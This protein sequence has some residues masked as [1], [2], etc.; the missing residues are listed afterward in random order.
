MRPS[1]IR[2]L[3]AL[4]F[5]VLFLG[6]LVSAAADYTIEYNWW[7]EIG[8]V[9][10][11]F[12]M[13]WYSI[14]PAAAGTVVAFAAL[15]MTHASGLHFAGIRQRDFPIYSR[16]IPV[17][18]ALVAILFAT[19]SIDYWTAMRFFGSRGIAVPADAWKDQVFSRGLPFYLFDLPFYSQ[20][21]GFVFVLA[22]LCAL[23]FWATARGWQLAERF[24]YGRLTSGPGNQ[25]VLG[26]DTLL[27]PGAT[28]AGI[29]RIISVIL[30]LGFAV[31]IFLG[32]YELLLNSHAF[33]TGADFVDQKI[34]LPLRY[35]LIVATIGALPLIWI[36]RYKRAIIVV[37]SFFIL[38]FALPGLVQAVYVRPNEISIERPYIQRHIEA[39]TIAFGLD[40]KATER[41]FI[42]SPQATVDPVQDATLL[43]NVRLW[44]LRA[45]NAT[46]TQIQALR[47]YYTFPETDVDRYFPNGRIKQVL[48]S[49]RELDVSQLSAEASQSWINP[50]FIYTHGFGVV[51]AEVNKI[52]PDGLP[53]LLIENAPPEVKVPGFQ[54]TR[55]EIYFGGKTQ[56][57][58]FVHTAREEFDYPSGDQNKYSTYQGSGGFPVGSFPLKI[59]AAL[60]QGEPNIIF[61]GYLTGDSRMMIHRNVQER[62]QYLAGF[63]QWDQDPYLVIADDGSLVWMVDGY[64]T[65]LSHPYSATIPVAGLEEGANYIRNAVKATVDA[66]SGKINL[67]VFDPGD[68]IIQAYEHLFPK[69]FRPASEMPADIRRHARY[70]EALFRA[71]AEAYRTYHMR[72][73]QVFY[74]KEDIWEIA[75]NLFGQSQQPEPVQPTYVVA[76]LPG[77]KQPE[78]LLILPFTPRAKDN[79]IGWMAARCDADHLGELVFFQLPKQQLMYGPMQIESRIDQDQNISKDLTLWNQQGSHVLRGNII[80][81]PVTG[82]FLYVETIY[83]QANEARMPQLKKVVLAMGDR[84][85]YRDTFDEALA[86]LTG[87]P[88]PAKPPSAEVAAAPAPTTNTKAAPSL[89]ERIRALRQ[90]SEQLTRELEKLEQDA[91]KK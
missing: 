31:W 1:Q 2:N 35:L 88:A 77:E 8:Q 71:Q 33:M 29:V 74:N 62:L 5:S 40:R 34:T 60:S 75:H 6:W 65:S 53:V 73:P 43:D 89:A 25:L 41:P 21:L 47:P 42:P 11:W 78:F 36:R 26:P 84:L 15:W 23:A 28:R 61:T 24:R 81:L 12:G 63:L 91:G 55:P 30:L 69:L 16:L 45:Y 27:L 37:I 68:P 17:V 83:I 32:N 7:K 82:G 86:D 14:A 66:Y 10:T 54:I 48:L 80:A 59:A 85:I 87:S 58:V 72:D 56:D 49:P 51:M 67:Y 76:T 22:I 70:P 44:D 38:Q 57:P 3:I 46:I 13:L 64:T 20:V 52:T 90:Q 4:I 50:R 39:T 19:S 9:D 79:L 18:L